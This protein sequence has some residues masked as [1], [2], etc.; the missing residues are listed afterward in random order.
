MRGLF[1]RANDRRAPRRAEGPC[2]AA[3]SLRLVLVLAGA[4]GAGLGRAH[5]SP[6]P[7]AAVVQRDNGHYVLSLNFDV[8]DALRRTLQ[9]AMAPAQFL[10]AF[11]AMDAQEFA[12]AW[13]RA[14]DAWAR[15]CLLE[16]AARPQPARRWRWPAAAQA[17]AQ[18][19]ERLMHGLTAGQ[20]LPASG[21][22]AADPH[23]PHLL[24]QAQADFRVAGAGTAPTKL[25]L[26]P[27]LRPLSVTSYRAHQ[28]WVGAGDGAVVLRF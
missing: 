16:A 4:L 28:Q 20:S 3:R 12:G 2:R 25:S 11:S 15:A 21:A 14:T 26:H 19:R 8:A 1:S 22:G 23:E 7:S 5:E 24:A 9:P 17:Q 13:A 18:I 27:A 6:S 10:A